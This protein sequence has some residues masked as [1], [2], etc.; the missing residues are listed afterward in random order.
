MHGQGWSGFT[1]LVRRS[2]RLDEPGL[3]IK[4]GPCSNGE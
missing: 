2:E 1:A 3:P 4:L